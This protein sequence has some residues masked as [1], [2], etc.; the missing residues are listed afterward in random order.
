M[1][2]LTVACSHVTIATGLRPEFLH[3]LNP[4]IDKSAA[5]AVTVAD[6]SKLFLYETNIFYY[7]RYASANKERPD[8]VP[9]K[10]SSDKIIRLYERKAVA[11]GLTS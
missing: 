11:E 3:K 4:P 9:V 5:C 1:V 6:S 10:S 2:A 8:V 7:V